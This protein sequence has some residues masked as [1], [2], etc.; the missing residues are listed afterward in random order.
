MA[1]ALFDSLIA[2]G[3]WYHPPKISET[4]GSMTMTFLSD[5]KLSKE[6]WKREKLK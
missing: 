2:S 3:G 6:A 1:F 4:T 5:V